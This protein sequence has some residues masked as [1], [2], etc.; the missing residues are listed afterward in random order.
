MKQKQ[1]FFLTILRKVNVILSKTTVKQPSSKVIPLVTI[2]LL[3]GYDWL[4]T[5][6]QGGPFLE[7]VVCVLTSNEV[8]FASLA[9]NLTV[10]FS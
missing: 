2:D 6:L 7:K 9:D 3:A 4:V 1:I 5:T 8:H 10:P